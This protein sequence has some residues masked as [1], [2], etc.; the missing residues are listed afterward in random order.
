MEDL[1]LHQ[2][3]RSEIQEL[4]QEKKRILNPASA[5][6]VDIV[7]KN[8]SCIAHIYEDSEYLGITV[9]KEA[10]D[11]F[12]EISKHASKRKATPVKARPAASVDRAIPSPK[13]N[14]F[15]K[16]EPVP[17]KRP[18]VGGAK[19]VNESN[20]KQTNNNLLRMNKLGNSGSKNLS[21]IPED[22]RELEREDGSSKLFVKVKRTGSRSMINDEEAVELENEAV[23][24][25]DGKDGRPEKSTRELMNQQGSQ[26]RKKPEE[27]GLHEATGKE[28]PQEKNITEDRAYPLEN[29]LLRRTCKYLL[30]L[31]VQAT[32]RTALYWIQPGLC[33]SQIHTEHR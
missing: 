3:L 6:G 2:K 22:C 14:N 24:Q 30:S 26:W 16:K 28:M 4:K 31:S 10:N 18:L 27:E 20:P 23:K 29:T 19:T 15:I 11:L 7:G 5:Q 33:F 12:S 21:K 25:A 32:H 17:A 8:N 9:P 13:K 1:K